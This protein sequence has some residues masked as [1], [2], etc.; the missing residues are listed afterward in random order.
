[1]V[2]TKR[3]GDDEA[4]TH[5]PET[6]SRLVPEG[7]PREAE[8]PPGQADARRLE[9]VADLQLLAEILD[10][11]ELLEELVRHDA[12]HYWDRFR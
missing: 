3:G 9:A 12:R 1:M 4:T 2:T 6:E 10:S 7:Q 11:D 8:E 5:E